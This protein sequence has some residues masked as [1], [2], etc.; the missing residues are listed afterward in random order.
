MGAVGSGPVVRTGAVKPVHRLR[1]K[2]VRIASAVKD[3]W[4]EDV[5]WIQRPRE[6]RSH[7]N[8]QRLTS[9]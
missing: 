7:W 9:Y 2:S 4:G 8:R 6:G 5:R 3:L 1:P